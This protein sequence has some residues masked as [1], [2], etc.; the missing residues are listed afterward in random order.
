[1]L[2]TIV[3]TDY[4]KT[5]P[6]QARCACAGCRIARLPAPKAGLK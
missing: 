4:G 3:I 1:M 2:T 5:H 6:P